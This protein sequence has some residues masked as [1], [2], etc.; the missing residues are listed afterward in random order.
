[1]KKFMFILASIVVIFLL[2]LGGYAYYVYHSVKKTAEQMHEPNVNEEPPPEVN[3]T[4]NPKPIS[5][6]LMGVDQ[7][8][9]DPGR[10][11]T[12]IVITL[13][14]SKEKMMMISIPRD[15]RTEIIGKGK[16]DKINHAYAFG[17]TKMSIDTVENFV[18]IP[19]NYYI[20]VNMKALEELVDAVGGITV[21]NNVDW[22][23]EG[24]YKKGYHYKKGSI[25]LDGPQ[26]LGYVRMRHLDPQGDFGRNERQRKVITAIIDKASNISSVTRITNILH[27]L[28][29][30]VKTNMTFDEMMNIQKNYRNSQNHITQYE[31]HGN[32]ERINGIYYL[33]VPEEERVKITND[34][35]E[36]LEK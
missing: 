18:G 11:D 14:P 32:G 29:K 33:V 17:G 12:L 3:I 31:V 9:G 15:T 7:R 36:S 24:Y 5:I 2:G 8:K 1:M 28:G 13:N 4:G 27:A 34:L 22:Y 19:I 20:R 23:D 10:T 25:T 21:Q 16:M 35:K 26:S 30:N 6:L